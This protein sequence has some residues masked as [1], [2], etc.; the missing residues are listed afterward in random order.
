[1]ALV[2]FR[3]LQTAGEF[4]RAVINGLRAEGVR[5]SEEQS[6]SGE[7]PVCLVVA[8]TSLDDRTATFVQGAGAVCIAVCAEASPPEAV[9]SLLQCGAADVIH[10]MDAATAARLASS[11]A[12][13]IEKI[14]QLLLSPGIQSTFVGRSPSWRRTLRQLVEVAHFSSTGVLITGESGTGKELAARL[15]HTLDARATRG[16][17][18]L[19]DC[20][21]ISPELAGSELFGHVRGAYTG[22]IAEREGALALANGGTLFL[23]ELGELPLPVQAQLLRAIEEGAFKPVGAVQWR[24]TNFRLVC[25]TNRDLAADVQARRFRLDLYHRV[26]AWHVHLPPLRERPEDIVPLAQHFARSVTGRRS[27]PEFDATVRQYL[28]TREY[29]GNLRDLRQLMART[30]TRHEGDGP[31]TPGDLASE[32]RP[33]GDARVWPDEHFERAVRRGLQ[34]GQGMKAIGRDAEAVAMRLA[35]EDAAGSSRRAAEALGVTERAVQMR[36][37]VAD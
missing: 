1:M 23:D 32:D 12:R 19:L 29:P 25:A 33:A 21:T 10:G 3:S 6:P 31:I 13:R 27:A 8:T 17:F 26:M 28:V 24:R 7:D 14:E 18:V 35:L 15:I 4:D 20:G 5:V 9:W 34:R 30:M 16:P 11:R 37:A 36:R 22:A 2:A